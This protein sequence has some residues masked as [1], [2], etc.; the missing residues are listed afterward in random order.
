V[1]KRAIFPVVCGTL[2]LTMIAAF[3]TTSHSLSSTATT[4][5][6]T[7]L[8]SSVNDAGQAIRY[9]QGGIPEVTMLRV[10]I[11]PGRETGWHTHPAP[12]FAYVI[13]G[14]LTVA[15]KDGR[16]LRFTASQGLAE[17]V[18]VLH[19][20]KNLGATPVELVVVYLGEKRHPIVVRP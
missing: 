14:T 8:K 9:P 11:P 12:S 3:A 2:L 13:S 6:V 16:Q 10:E 4:K 19:D 15:L 7:I 5:V 1:K 17:S 18:D 20:G